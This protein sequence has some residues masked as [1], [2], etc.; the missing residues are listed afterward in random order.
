LFLFFR[1]NQ[2]FIL[3]SEKLSIKNVSLNCRL[4]IFLIEK[5]QA[6]K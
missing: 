5:N 6:Y 4:R 3:I 2:I 1:T